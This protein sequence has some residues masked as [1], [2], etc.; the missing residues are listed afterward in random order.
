MRLGKV[1]VPGLALLGFALFCS[2]PSC[3]AQEVNPD[4]FTETG[5]EPFSEHARPV[6]KKDGQSA[7]AAQKNVVTP[8]MK[9]ASLTEAVAKPRKSSKASAKKAANPASGK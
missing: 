2:A 1:T 4:H 5:V 6:A 9:E 8:Q 3:K 7:Q